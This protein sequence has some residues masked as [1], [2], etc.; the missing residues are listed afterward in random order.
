MRWAVLI[1]AVVIAA[2]VVSGLFVDREFRE[3]NRRV[4]EVQE[5][6]ESETARADSAVARGRAAQAAADLTRAE[7]VRLTIA[8][9]ERIAALDTV[10]PEECEEVVAV[11]DTLIREVLVESDTWRLAFEKQ[12][13][14][15]TQFISAQRRQSVVIDS[16]MLVLDARPRPRPAWLPTVSVGPF[17]GFCV[18]GQ[19]CA[20][21]GVGLTWKVRFP[22]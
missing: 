5:F 2:A 22:I 11:R 8:N 12:R 4:E 18:N 14:A 7:A 19:P 9:R 6:A 17:V 20:G 16:L 1:A 21:I 13:K 15:S 3:W 10:V